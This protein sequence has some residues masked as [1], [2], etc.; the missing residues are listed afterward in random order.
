MVKKQRIEH[1]Y[2]KMNFIKG[3]SI[4]KLGRHFK[5]I[6]DWELNFVSMKF[7]S[8]VISNLKIRDVQYIQR[9]KQFVDRFR[10]INK[11]LFGGTYYPGFTV[12]KHVKHIKHIDFTIIDLHRK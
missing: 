6:S 2:L 11:D 4:V 3:F 10:S 5:I 1:N 7:T 12:P 8:I 9:S